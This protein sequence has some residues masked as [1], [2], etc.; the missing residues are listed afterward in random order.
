MASWSSKFLT[1]GF[2]P[3]VNTIALHGLYIYECLYTDNRNSINFED[4]YG[5]DLCQYFIYDVIILILSL[6]NIC[7][8]LIFCI[9]FNLE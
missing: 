4:N 2:I 7:L 9:P 8:G 6:T 1:I 5:L 3:F